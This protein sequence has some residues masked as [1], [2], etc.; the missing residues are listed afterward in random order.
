MSS[1]HFYINEDIENIIKERDKHSHKGNYGR[2][3]LIAGS[4][5]MMGAALLS[6][7]AC[8][9][10]GLGILSVMTPSRGEGII[11]SHLPEVL[12]IDGGNE[13]YNTSLPDL[14]TYKSIG[15]GPGLS[16]KEEVVQLIKKLLDQSELPLV[17]DADALNILA[18]NPD[19]LSNIPKNSILTP[20]PKEFERLVGSFKDDEEKWQKQIGLSKKLGVV[21][22]VKGAYTSI[23]DPNGNIYWNTNGNPGMAKGGSGDVLTG[24]ILSFLAQGYTSLQAALLACFQH[25]KAGDLAK[26]KFGEHQMIARDIIDEI[27]F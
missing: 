16:Q 24:M 13:D 21:V 26:E 19:L 25:G 11:H 10:T 8:L 18:A 20:H 15:I 3:C 7:K 9:R 5:G 2:A 12:W 6:A 4:K 14:S 17:I 1:N 27:T 23:S 22:L